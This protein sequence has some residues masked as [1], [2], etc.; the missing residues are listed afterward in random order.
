MGYK[1]YVKDKST[2]GRF[3]QW[4]RKNYKSRAKAHIEMTKAEGIYAKTSYRKLF[5]TPT[6]EIRKTALKDAVR[7]KMGSSN[8]VARETKISGL[9]F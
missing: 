1:I 7:N 6:F 3:E 9:G 2:K 8:W 4:D 5:G